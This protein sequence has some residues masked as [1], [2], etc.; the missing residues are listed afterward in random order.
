MIFESVLEHGC[1]AGGNG[2][3][4]AQYLS[5]AFENYDF[6]EGWEVPKS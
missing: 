3:H 1:R 5:S 2:H 4:V 6:E